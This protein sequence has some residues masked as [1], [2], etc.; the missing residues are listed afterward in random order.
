VQNVQLLSGSAPEAFLELLAYD[1]RLFNAA[2]RSGQALQLRDWLVASDV[3]LSV[4]ALMLEPDVVMDLAH[5][6]VAEDN[7]YSRT[8]AAVRTARD[9]INRAV[10]GG[11]VR[12]PEREQAWLQRLS[13]TVDALPETEADAMEEVGSKYAHLYALES[14]GLSAA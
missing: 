10:T 9:A 3:P 14:Y 13:E 1:C 8:L 5:A 11:M 12:L 2:Q 6:V 7:G 4:E